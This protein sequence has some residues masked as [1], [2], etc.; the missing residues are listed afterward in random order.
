MIFQ[1]G[2]VTMDMKIAALL[3]AYW[4]CHRDEMTEDGRKSMHET[5]DRLVAEGNKDCLNG[6]LACLVMGLPDEQQDAWQEF[7]EKVD[8][9]RERP[10]MKMEFDK[11]SIA[12]QRLEQAGYF[13]RQNFWCCQSCGWADVPE[14]HADKAVF[15]HEQDDERLV[16]TG[17]A[18]LCWSGDA[19]FI[20]ET[21]EAA[22]IATEWD[23]NDRHRIRIM[24]TKCH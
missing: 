2:E 18:S 11:L 17:E 1:K 12:F 7:V 13:A 21:F 4:Q 9:E 10:A 19:R 15:Y 23:G 8:C 22:G 5:V 6:L 14:S 3:E 20:C 24:G 16:R